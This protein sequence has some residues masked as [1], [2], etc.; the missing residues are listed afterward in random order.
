MI[1]VIAALPVE[2]GAFRRHYQPELLENYGKNRHCFRADGID[3]VTCGVGPNN[4]AH[5]LQNYLKNT[6]PALLI[7][8]GMAGILHADL[9]V[10]TC[11]SVG[12][13]YSET[14]DRSF[15]LLTDPAF[16][17]VNGVSVDVPVTD[18]QRAQH[19]HRHLNADVVDMECYTIS[20]LAHE[21]D[22]PLYSYKI[23]TDYADE[24]AVRDVIRIARRASAELYA[25]ISG[26][27][28]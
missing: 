5:S 12:N 28:P 19:L 17:I 15:Q 10:L 7:N 14:K 25:N 20:K 4:T 6:K 8:V 21:Y 26:K 13:I 9:P 22:I 3:C 11:V 24:N 2:M 18:P 1:T 23:T 27:L 16:P